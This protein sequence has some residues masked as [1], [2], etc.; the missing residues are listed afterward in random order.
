MAASLKPEEIGSYRRLLEDLGDR[1]RG[2]VDRMTDEA[3]RRNQGEASTNL[4]NVPLHMADVGT[5]NYD[6]EFTLGLI[7]NEQET[8]KLI[9]EAMVRIGDGTYGH[10]AECDQPIAKARLSALPYTRYCIECAR[11][12]ENPE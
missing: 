3:L 4:S 1:L 9:D 10:C 8:L 2:N 12:L 11:K 7:E 5:E 6:Q